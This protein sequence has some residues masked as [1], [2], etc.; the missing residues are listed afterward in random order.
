MFTMEEPSILAIIVMRYVKYQCC[1]NYNHQDAENG[2][3]KVRGDF[4]PVYSRCM[5]WRHFS[6]EGG[7]GSKLRNNYSIINLSGN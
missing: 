4:D 2:K 1:A 7:G 5:T 6:C 3:L